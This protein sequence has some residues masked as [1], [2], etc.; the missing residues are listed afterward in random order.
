MN[1]TTLTQ[2]LVAATNEAHATR[3]QERSIALAQAISDRRPTHWTHGFLPTTTRLSGQKVLSIWTMVF[4]IG[5][6]AL[7]YLMFGTNQTYAD[8]PLP[9]GNV[10]ARVLISLAQF[11]AAMGITTITTSLALEYVQGWTRA[12]ALTPLGLRPWLVAKVLSGLVVSFVTLLVIYALGWFL[13]AKMEGVVWVETFVLC[14]VLSLI[15]ALIGL[16]AAILIGS[17]EA[18][19]A[20]GGGMSILGFF[21]GMF[22]PLDQLGSVFQT[23][24]KFTPLWGINQVALAPLEGWEKLDWQPLANIGMYFVLLVAATAWTARRLTRR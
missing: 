20:L 16:V 7:M 17:D 12:I 2:S 4:T 21:S 1:I 19:G 18:Y 11:G 15:P 5:I 9:H 22:I 13:A 23:I 14:L 6:P 24:A 10:S 8:L 3:S